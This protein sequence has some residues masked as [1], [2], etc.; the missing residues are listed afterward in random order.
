MTVASSNMSSYQLRTLLLAVLISN[1]RFNAAMFDQPDQQSREQM[2]TS[3]TCF[4]RPYTFKVKQDDSEGRSCWDIV[5][6]TSCWGRCDSNEVNDYIYFMSYSLQLI[7]CKIVVNRLQIGVS[8]SSVRNIPSVNTT[9][10][11]H[12]LLSYEIAIQ[13]SSLARKSW[14]KLKANESN[15]GIFDLTD[16]LNSRNAM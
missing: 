8:R 7:Y 9:Q 1:I 15:G 2:E 14:N 3:P 12:A 6:V 11:S 13:K 10:F 4:R 5:T 16:C